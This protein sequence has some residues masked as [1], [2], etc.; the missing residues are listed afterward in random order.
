MTS[1]PQ[2][3]RAAAW[4][5]TN[6]DLLLALGAFAAL[7]VDPIFSDRSDQFTPLAVLLAVAA[8]IPLTCRRRYPL[9]VLATEI[10][11]LLLCLSVFHPSRAAVGIV[12]LTVFTVAYTGGRIRSLTVGALMAP[13]VA[14][15]VFITSKHGGAADVIA[16]LALVLG[17]LIAGD[18]ARGRRRIQTL[19]AEETERKR[20]AAA[21]QHF[22]Q[23]RLALAQ[24]VHDVIGHALVGINVRAAGAARLHRRGGNAD[25]PAVLD[26]IAKTSA[27]A[28]N[29]LRSTLRVLRPSTDRPMPLHPLQGLENLAELV[30]TMRRAGLTVF[31]AVEGSLHTITPAI[32]HAAFR[33]IQESLTNVMR[34]STS[35]QATVKVKLSQDTLV[36]E[37]TDGG[38]PRGHNGSDH[39]GHGIEGMKERAAALDGTLQAGPAQDGGWQVHASLPIIA[40]SRS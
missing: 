37:V 13:V 21:Q 20:T 34:H 25:L 4:Q 38:R 18:A 15:A 6:L 39:R 28:L 32:G 36:L 7:L 1:S 9:G 22:D 35:L 26:E 2:E 8:A 12:M 27:D 30:E 10:P 3:Q 16:Y 5:A 24:E 40:R 17:A 14:T 31:T 11:V 33:I 19:V 29:E 23:E